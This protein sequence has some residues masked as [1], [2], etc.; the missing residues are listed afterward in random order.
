[1]IITSATSVETMRMKRIVVEVQE[2][3]G[4]GKDQE[5]ISRMHMSYRSISRSVIS[6][7]SNVGS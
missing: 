7:A 6:F 5:V 3:Q 1:M 2:Q 4:Q